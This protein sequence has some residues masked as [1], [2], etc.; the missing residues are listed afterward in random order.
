[1]DL[2]KIITVWLQL[3]INSIVVR[4]REIDQDFMDMFKDNEH[5]L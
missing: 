1:M 3:D 4:M 2:L 5:I